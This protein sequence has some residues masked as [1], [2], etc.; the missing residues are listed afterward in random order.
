VDAFQSFDEP[1]IHG[2]FVFS[3][4]GDSVPGYSDMVSM[5]AM[6]GELEWTAHEYVQRGGI[7]SVVSLAREVLSHRVKK[8]LDA[9]SHFY[10]EATDFPDSCLGAPKPSE[11]CEQVVTQGFRI[12]LVADGLLYEFHTDVFGYDIRPFGEPQVAPTRGPG[13]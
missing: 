11:V 4:R 13:G 5:Q 3:G 9:S 1:S 7:P 12:Q 8:W 10:F 2:L 6:I